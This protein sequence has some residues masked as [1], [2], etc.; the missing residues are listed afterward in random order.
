MK[1]YFRKKPKIDV[2]G[3]VLDDDTE[4]GP[5]PSKRAK[6]DGV[7][8]G[9][10]NKPVVDLTTE[11]DDQVEQMVCVGI[12]SLDLDKQKFRGAEMLCKNLCIY[13]M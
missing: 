2:V 4:D 5:G 8:N 6:F 9:L 12:N 11:D 3:S 10:A 1:S 13:T 7:G